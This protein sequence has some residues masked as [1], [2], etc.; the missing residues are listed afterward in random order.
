MKKSLISVAV[1]AAL[2]STQVNAGGPN[3]NAKGVLNVTCVEAN[4]HFY[5]AVM[6]QRGEKSP[7]FQLRFADLV[8][9]PTGCVEADALL[10]ELGISVDEDSD[11]ED[12]GDEDSDNEDSDNE[13]SD[14]E[15]SGD[16]DSISDVE[17]S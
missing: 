7:N 8:E 6:D 2:S 15:D 13:D 16:D 1:L 14:N 9:D 3:F 12:S 17:P 4:G 11:D 10:T 5:N